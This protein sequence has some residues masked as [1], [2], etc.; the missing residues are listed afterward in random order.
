[1]S[2]VYDRLERAFAFPDR[3]VLVRAVD[4]AMEALGAS[5]S[6]D[7]LRDAV[8]EAIDAP[9]RVGL[10]AGAGRSPVHVPELYARVADASGV[11]PGIA[12]EIAQMHFQW[13]AER[14]RPE[15]R[16]ELRQDLG[17]EWSSL[18]MDARPPAR[19]PGAHVHVPPMPGPGRTLAD[20][21]PGSARPLA[22]SR[23]PSGQRDS[24][25][26]TDD[27]KGD[28][29]LSGGRPPDPSSTDHSLATGEPGAGPR[30]VSRS[31]E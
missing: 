18:L 20:G 22:S 30:S 1:M 23:P 4:A 6:S 19:E 10:R 29:K 17:R 11:E 9:L 24:I 5:I 25:S 21:A 3:I 26:G 13:L 14:L 27:P 2:D 16:H 31:G 15:L 8:A 7:P 12:V 28:S